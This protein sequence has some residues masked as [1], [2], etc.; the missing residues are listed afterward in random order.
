MDEKKQ[1][2]EALLAQS[3]TNLTNYGKV[4]IEELKKELFEIEDYE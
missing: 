4:R 2:L 1:E 3:E